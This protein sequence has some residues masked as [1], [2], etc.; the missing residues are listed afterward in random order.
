[1]DSAIRTDAANCML[2]EA[3]CGL[4]VEH[5]GTRIQRVRGDERDPLS[6]G[7]ICP[8]AAAI[9]DLQHDPDR[10][11][12]P[13]E[14]DGSRFRPVSWERA[15]SRTA[16][17]LCELQAQHGKNAV[18]VY[19]GNPTGHSY[20]A[21]LASIVFESVLGSDN[22]YSA[23]SVDALPRQLVSFAMYGNQ[24]LLAVP[25][26]DRTDYLLVLGANPAVSN[27]S[28]MSCPGFRTRLRALRQR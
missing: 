4:L 28:I 11:T 2:C 13:L 27:G 23:A 26:I 21:K 3:S 17:A 7:Y 24:A 10:V 14:R 9:A 16:E 6:R 5:D 8:K 1:M 12:Q 19:P 20:S 15:L 22:K 18:A 25:D